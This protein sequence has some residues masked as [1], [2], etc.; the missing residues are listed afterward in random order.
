MIG[1]W[2]TSA[3]EPREE[4]A[5]SRLRPPRCCRRARISPADLG[6]WKDAHIPELERIARFIHSQGARA[7][8]QLAHAGRKA[9]MTPPFGG[10]RLVLPG[11][12]GWQPVAP[13]AVAFSSSYAV[14]T[15]LDDAGI[16]A[17]VHAFA[18]AAERALAA[19]FDFVE[20]HAAHGYLIHQFLSPLVQPPER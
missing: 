15:A 20:I 14:P 9:S 19:G 1:T 17:V 5:W 6:I 4:Q 18:E 7:G 8:I 10:E 13:S 11:E 2:F 16:A 12:G 3:A